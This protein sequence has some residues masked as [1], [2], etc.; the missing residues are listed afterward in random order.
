MVESNDQLLRPWRDIVYWH[1]KRAM[2]GQAGFPLERPIWLYLEF[3]LPRLKSHY[4]K[5]GLKP[6]APVRHQSRPDISKL[7]RAVED[8]LTTAGVYRDDMQISDE[9]LLK[10]YGEQP[11]VWILA[12]QYPGL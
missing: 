11:G 7:A 2:A 5:H 1:A 8:S 6:K 10:R 4:A 9:V 3:V 12:G